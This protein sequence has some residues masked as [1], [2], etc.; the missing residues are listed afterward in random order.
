LEVEKN[1]SKKST[2]NPNNGKFDK[3]CVRQATVDEGEGDGKGG[4]KTERYRSSQCTSGVA[5]LALG[6]R[7]RQ[8]GCKVV[9]QREGSPGAKARGSPGV[10]QEEAQE[11]HH[12]LPG[13]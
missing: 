11:S 13:V 8:R 1:N 12:I 9:G 3:L 7:P 10:R 5:T 4:C 2:L 6:S